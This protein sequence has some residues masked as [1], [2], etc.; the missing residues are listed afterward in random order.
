MQRAPVRQLRAHLRWIRTELPHVPSCGA[1]LRRLR[2]DLQGRRKQVRSVPQY[3]P[4]LQPVRPGVHGKTER[5]PLLPQRPATAVRGLRQDVPRRHAD[6]P[7][8]PGHRA[9]LWHLWR[10]LPRHRQQ[11][12]A[13]PRRRETMRPVRTAGPGVQR[14]VLC[15]PHRRPAVHHLWQDFP[16]AHPGMQGVLWPVGG[17]WARQ[18]SPET[19]CPGD[20]TPSRRGV[21]QG[22]HIWSLRLLRRNRWHRRPRPGAVPRRPRSRVQPRA[23]L[24]VMQLQ[25]VRPAADRMGSGPCRTWSRAFASRCGRTGPGTGSGA[26][27]APAGVAL[28]RPGCVPGTLKVH[29]PPDRTI[30]TEIR[31]HSAVPVGAGV[32][33][34]VPVEI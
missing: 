5:L 1:Y 21:S 28:N 13:L 25:Q 27:T 32:V 8:M 17:R 22:H 10:V 14:T 18:A 11:L 26:H 9:H 7:E 2:Q 4:D 16:G 15:L 30:G 6:L 20:R 33:R 23:C 3:G 34:G 24:R 19:R 12:L 31:E 29:G